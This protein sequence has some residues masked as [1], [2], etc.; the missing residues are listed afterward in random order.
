VQIRGLVP[1]LKVPDPSDAN[2]TVPLGVLAVPA[3]VSVTVAVQVDS[4]A[5]GTVPGEQFTLGEVERS[6]Q[7][8][9]LVA[10]A[11]RV[12]RVAGVAGRDRAR[13]GIRGAG[14]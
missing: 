9:R 1:G 14:V 11:G 5:S 2:P 6:L 7:G 13:P 8:Q 3:A 10:G 12:A 4:V